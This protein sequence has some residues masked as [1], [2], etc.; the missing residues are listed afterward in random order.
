MSYGSRVITGRLGRGNDLQRRALLAPGHRKHSQ[1]EFPRLRTYRHQRRL[2]GARLR[3]R[4]NWNRGKHAVALA[5]S[6][7]WDWWSRVSILLAGL[8]RLAAA[9]VP[10][11]RR[12]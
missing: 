11:W 1:P 8:G 2:H 9:G 6:A 5:I 3:Q 7:P 10:R 12:R 4:L